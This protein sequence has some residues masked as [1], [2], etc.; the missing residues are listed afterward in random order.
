M[1]AE[2]AVTI[3]RQIV[4]DDTVIQVLNDLQT[5]PQRAKDAK[6]VQV[7]V[8]H[9]VRLAAMA[10]QEA[11]NRVA[12]MEGEALFEAQCA[13][14]DDGKKLYTNEAQRKTA[15]QRDLQTDPAYAEAIQTQMNARKDKMMVEMRAGK[16]HNSVTHVFTEFKAAVAASFLIG[17]LSQ[18]SHM[19]E[20]MER[21]AIDHAAVRDDRITLNRMKTYITE[22][23]Q[24]GNGQ[25]PTN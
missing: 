14:G 10:L 21:M 2:T 23:L 7:E 8:E 19:N 11:E 3:R 6:N 9:E 25:K 12:E 5:L 4:P 22:E 20:I 16:I 1:S 24:N 17:S 15:A 18:E 13:V